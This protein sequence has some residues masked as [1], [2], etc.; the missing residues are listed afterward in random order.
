MPFN[1]LPGPG[2][3]KG[4]KNGSTKAKAWAEQDGGWELIIRMV[5][6]TEPNF[7]RAPAVRADLAKFL[8]DRA[9]GKASQSVELSGPDGGP[10]DIKGV[11]L[12]LFSS[13]KEAID[14]E[15]ERNDYVIDL[16]PI[17]EDQRKQIEASDLGL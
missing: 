11:I 12:D 5:K 6:G 3:P 10:I 7:T 1:G 2:R 13:P 17:S 9:Y 16:D 15:V 4:S 14:V 8:I